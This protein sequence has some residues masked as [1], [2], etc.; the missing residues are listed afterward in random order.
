MRLEYTSKD[1]IIFWIGLHYGIAA[2]AESFSKE[3]LLDNHI[4]AMLQKYRDYY[5][6]DIDDNELVKLMADWSV[7]LN[8]DTK[9]LKAILAERMKDAFKP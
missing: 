6:H 9:L 4:F 8:D 2:V 1:R 3:P 5:S 7:I